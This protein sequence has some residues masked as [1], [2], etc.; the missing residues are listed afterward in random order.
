MDIKLLAEN[1]P[2]LFSFQTSELGTLCCFPLRVK[3]WERVHTK[4]L[5]GLS[6]DEWV[7]V[8][9]SSSCNKEESLK[10][11]QY[12][13]DDSVLSDEEVTQLSQSELEDFAMK[14]ANRDSFLKKYKDDNAQKK[15][16]DESNAAYLRRIYNHHQTNLATSK[17]GKS[18][19]EALQQLN[20]LTGAAKATDILSASTL[21]SIAKLKEQERSLAKSW[22]PQLYSSPP[23]IP[24]SPQISAAQET[25]IHLEDLKNLMV[26]SNEVQE[27]ISKDITKAI[28][29]SK[30]VSRWNLIISGAVLLLTLVGLWLAFST[31]QTSSE[32][33]EKFIERMDKNST[34]V[35]KPLESLSSSVK[36]SDEQNQKLTTAIE[37]LGT[38]VRKLI[39]KPIKDKTVK[40][41][42]AG[43]Q[44]KVK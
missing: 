26:T 28:A 15:R 14:F 36:S 2:P 20:K 3:D 27:G 37:T 43:N 21:K 39:K 35:V 31:A 7:R 5:E 9:I 25:V 33:M 17:L 4:Q 10:D 22:Q 30:N 32:Q 29:D 12:K 41:S 42:T 40:K 1:L 38:E 11:G 44:K 23:K 18:A 34:A 19:F 24:I 16:D 6:D 8:F 13:P